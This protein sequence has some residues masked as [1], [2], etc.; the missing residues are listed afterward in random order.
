VSEKREQSAPEVEAEF[1]KWFES[2]T[3]CKYRAFYWSDVRM[4]EGFEAGFNAALSL[5]VAVPAPE[6]PTGHGCSCGDPRCTYDERY[7]NLIRNAPTVEA[8][9]ERCRFVWTVEGCDNHCELKRHK[10]PHWTKSEHWSD[11]AIR[12]EP[13]KNNLWSPP[14]PAT[15]SLHERSE[16]ASE[17]DNIPKWAADLAFEIAK[18]TDEASAHQRWLFD[19]WITHLERKI[20]KH[21]TL[22]AQAELRKEE[23]MPTDDT[24][25][26]NRSDTTQLKEVMPTERLAPEQSKLRSTTDTRPS[27]EVAGGPTCATT[28]SVIL[29]PQPTCTLCDL[30]MVLGAGGFYCPVHGAAL[31]GS[32]AGG[33]TESPWHEIAE[34]WGDGSFHDIRKA[35]WQYVEQAAHWSEQEGHK[36]FSASEV[37]GMLTDFAG[38]MS[39]ESAEQSIALAVE[40]YGQLVEEQLVKY[41]GSLAIITKSAIAKRMSELLERQK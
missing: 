35:A 39:I 12:P 9:G 22:E 4:R 33:P 40:A 27:G 16:T 17:R 30:G 6:A 7:G 26:S 41:P 31:D 36:Y 32:E 25:R 38:H 15:A 3:G 28:K 18:D 19:E 11:G 29:P 34:K 20:M 37:R 8:Q 2:K 23:V 1:L 24:T 10:G 14:A 13:P 5:P 21:A